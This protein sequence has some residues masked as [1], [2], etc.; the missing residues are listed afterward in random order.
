MRILIAGMQCFPWMA[1]GWA[2]AL[3]DLGQEIILW[4]W[5]PFFSSGLL[6]RVEQRILLGPGI[7]RLNHALVTFAQQQHPDLILL[8]GANPIL[9]STVRSL[10]RFA[11][12]AGYHNDDPFGHFGKRAYFRYWKQAL[13]EFHSHHVF[14]QVNVQDYQKAGVKHVKV[15]LPFFLPWLH[16]RPNL[17]LQEHRQWQSEIVFVGHA[18]DDRRIEHIKALLDAGFAVRVYGYP[19]TWKKHLPRPLLERLPT[20]RPAVGADYCK[21]IVSSKIALC[22]LSSGNRDQLTFRVFELTAV[23]AFMLCQR[24]DLAQEMFQ[25]DQEAV[26]FSSPQELVDKCR[27]YLTD[28]RRREEIAASGRNRCLTSNYD[29]HSRMQQW[30]SETTSWMS[31]AG[32][33]PP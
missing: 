24:S 12:V 3:Q 31:A 21:A 30:L 17:T 1:P 23:G 18:E 5:T 13:P 8:Y 6:G 32:T 29:I 20:I 15:L 14:R 28:D 27:V 25:E 26:Y 2:R 7:V 22:F 33:S 10:A 4:D 19:A 9:P 16:V 11:W